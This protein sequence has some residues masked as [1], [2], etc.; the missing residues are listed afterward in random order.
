MASTRTRWKKIPIDMVDTGANSSS[1]SEDSRDDNTT[2]TS[3]GVSSSL[4][5]DAIN[6]AENVEHAIA[7][8]VE[9]ERS[10]LALVVDA[11][12]L[13]AGLEGGDIVVGRLILSYFSSDPSS[14]FADSPRLRFGHL[15]TLKKSSP[16]MHMKKAY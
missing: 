5:F 8:R 9:S 13:V 7:H 15:R 6:S 14:A 4:T 2:V 10:I 16:Y 1:D 12:H 3:H 11:E